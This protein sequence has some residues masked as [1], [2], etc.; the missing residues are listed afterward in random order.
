MLA[1]ALV[2]LAGTSLYAVILVVVLSTLPGYARVVRTQTM[3]LKQAEFVLASVAR[4]PDLAG[5]PRPCHAQ[6]IGP[7]L[8]LAWMDM[9][10]VIT[11]EAGMSFLG[12]GRPPADTFLGFDPQ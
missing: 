4:R 9:P 5:P 1:L 8:I 2:T 7:L 12:L 11:I 10:V 3:S 6:L